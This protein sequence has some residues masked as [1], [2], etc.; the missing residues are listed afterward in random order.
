MLPDNVGYI[1]HSDFTDG[2]AEELRHALL[3]LKAQGVKS[4]ILDYR[5]NGG[6]I[7]QEAVKIVALFVPK[8]TEVVSMRGRGQGSNKQYFTETEPLDLN[9]PVAV[10]VDGQSAS[11]SEIVAGA[12]QDLDRGVVIGQRT[13]GKGLVQSTLPLGYDSYLKLTTAKY[14]TPSGR[15]IQAIDYSQ[16]AQTD[17]IGAP[18]QTAQRS[19]PD[20]LIREFR[21]VAGRKVYD[22]GGIMPDMRLDPEYSSRFAFIL[23]AKG[24]LDD[25]ADEW[26]LKNRS[27][28]TIAPGTFA[29]TDADWEAFTAFMA[30]KETG[31][32]SITKQSLGTLRQ[33]AEAERYLTDEMTAELD[34]VAALLEKSDDNASNMALHRKELTRLIES[35]IILRKCYSRGVSEHNLATDTEVARAAELL[36]DAAQYRE[37]LTK[38]DTERK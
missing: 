34:A 26:S 19:L 32:E 21:T 1:H 16:H 22:G 10:L 31:Y 17:S 28:R 30:G 2:S 5:G 9:I 12:F 33:A 23:Y 11:A 37:I 36:R 15:C 4:L 7:M 6:G 38:K 8:G 25:F 3:D 24:Y 20:S 27:Q 35:E 18:L 14:Y 13:F 29:L